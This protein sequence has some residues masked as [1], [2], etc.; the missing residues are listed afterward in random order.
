MSIV[1]NTNVPSLLAQNSLGANQAGLS[2]AMQRLSSGLRINTAADDPAGLAISLS[3]TQSANAVAQG[4]QNANSGISLIQTAEGAMNDIANIIEQM[5]TLA[6]QASNTTYTSTQLG[7][8]NTTFQALLTE[9]NRVANT[10]NFNGLNLLDG[11]NS[12]ISIQVGANNTANDRLTI[13]LNNLTTGTAGLSI[14]GLSVTSNA[15]AQSAVAS[16]QTALNSV[17]TALATAGAGEVNTTAAANNNNAIVANL[18]ASRS[19]IQDADFAAESSNL[20]RYNVLTQSNIS[21]LAQA[22]VIPQMAL[23]LIQ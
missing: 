17:T 2:Q 21:M 20:S 19:R 13:T 14:S 4:A 11:S 8:I 12:S 23:K 9:I 6:S 16:L 7:N 5:S 3:M 22:N 18:Q 15:N 10:A 1:V